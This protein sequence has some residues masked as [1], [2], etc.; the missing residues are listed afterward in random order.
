VNRADNR[1]IRIKGCKFICNYSLSLRAS[2]I[3]KFLLNVTYFSQNKTEPSGKFMFSNDV[4]NIPKPLLENRSTKYRNE[5]TL[6][7][8]SNCKGNVVPDLSMKVYGDGL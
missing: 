7:S 8:G 1:K 6:D 2:S 5:T 3:V 4:C